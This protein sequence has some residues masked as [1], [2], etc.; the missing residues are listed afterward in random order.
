MSLPA[1]ARD[2][3]EDRDRLV[4][5]VGRGYGPS[6]GVRGRFIIERA[7]DKGCPCPCGGVGM[8]RAPEE[9]VSDTGAIEGGGVKGDREW[10]GEAMDEVLRTSDPAVCKG[11]AGNVEGGE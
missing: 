11:Y 1:G 5:D 4:G 2:E 6:D 10:C 8:T 3:E 9:L 7:D